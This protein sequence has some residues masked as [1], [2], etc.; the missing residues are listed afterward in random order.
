MIG[1]AVAKR[2]WPADSPEWK[3]AAEQRRVYDYRSKL[4]SKIEQHALTHPKEYLT[5]CVQNRREADLFAALL[6]AA[7][8]D[9]NP[10]PPEQ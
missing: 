10:P 6:T 5:F 8:Y 3:A 1:V 2:V 4:Y 7:S 9:P